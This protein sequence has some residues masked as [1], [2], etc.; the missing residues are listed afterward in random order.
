MVQY[1]QIPQDLRDVPQWVLWR[2]EE[3]TDKHGVTKTTKVPYSTGGTRASSTDPAQWSPFEKCKDAYEARP[4]YYSG[5][6]FV[7]APTRTPTA[8]ST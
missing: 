5:I 8:V 2:A 3:A 7:F 6:G 4:D 1:D